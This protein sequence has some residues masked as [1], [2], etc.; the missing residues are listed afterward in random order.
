VSLRRR[1]TIEIKCERIPSMMISTLLILTLYSIIGTI[2]FNHPRIIHGTNRPLRTTIIRAT[3]VDATTTQISASSSETVI[4]DN[5]I[6]SV[7][8]PVPTAGPVLVD[9]ESLIVSS[10]E[11]LNTK[12]VSIYRDLSYSGSEKYSELG[13]KQNLL[14]LPGLDGIGNY[15]AGC[16]GKLN[17]VFNVWKMA[18]TG[19]DR[20]TFMELA[21]FVI[22]ALEKF[23]GPV[24]LVGESFGGL[25]ASYVAL[26]AKKGRVEKLI[27]INP[28]TSF[29][30]TNWNL[31]APIIANTGAA[32]PVIGI[33][34]LLATA[35]DIAQIRRIGSKMAS[36][37]TSP[38]E[39]VKFF[40]FA[41]GSSKYLL[42]SIPPEALSWRISKW[43]GIGISVM[44][45]KYSQIT[46]PTL[47]LIG[48]NDR[49]LP[50]SSEGKRLKKEMTGSAKVQV[51]EFDVGHALLEDG[52]VDFTDIILMSDIFAVPEEESLDCAMPTEKDMED[53]EKQVNGYYSL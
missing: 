3:T 16:V 23:D 11:A 31:V 26:R 48:K 25:L 34:A 29:D 21:A 13:K 12:T 8:N 39:V 24:I 27:L 6:N 42:D 7:E 41:L 37:M 18:T 45:D 35:V 53:V 33:S 44:K 19:D 10:L 36:L 17:D 38:D 43:F 46:A 9:S 2:A 51:K 32:F 40:N 49:L 14:F 22:Q 20:S 28:A 5:A 47:I 15:S 30:R 1:G 4:L 50:S 52:F